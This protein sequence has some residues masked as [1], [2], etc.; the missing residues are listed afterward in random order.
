MKTIF[1]HL[2]SRHCPKQFVSVR[3]PV[4]ALNEKVV[5][6]QNSDEIDISGR[7]CIVCQTP[8]HVAVF[9]NEG[10]LDRRNSASFEVA[11]LEGTQV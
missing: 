11:V 9:L 6:R 10:Q 7:H 1:R 2:V 8:M 4:G 3:I 5:L